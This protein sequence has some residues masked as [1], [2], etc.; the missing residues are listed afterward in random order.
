MDLQGGSKKK[1]E[2]GQSSKAKK[3]SG[4]PFK[5]IS[6]AIAIIT[7]QSIIF[8]P[9]AILPITIMVPRIEAFL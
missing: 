2:D 4:W 6:A 3:Q 5:T 1:Y 7:E 9:H 8:T